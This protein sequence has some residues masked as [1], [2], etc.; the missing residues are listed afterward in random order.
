MYGNARVF[1]DNDIDMRPQKSDEMVIGN[2]HATY[3]DRRDVRE[4]NDSGIKLRS[5]LF[6]TS[7]PVKCTRFPIALL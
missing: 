1:D 3:I 4:D 6:E 7:R 5:T 2:E